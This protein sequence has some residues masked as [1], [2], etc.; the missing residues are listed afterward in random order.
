MNAITIA[1]ADDHP[2]VLELLR[3]L[4][5]WSP[6]FRVVH[7]CDRGTAL[8]DAL[9]V[10]PTDIVVSDFSMSRGD[11]PLD[12]FMLLRKLREV[13]PHARRVLFTAQSNP[14]VFAAATRLG[15]SAI[16]SKEDAAVEVVRACR[17]LCSGGT[18]Y[19]SPTIRAIVEQ[20]GA[21]PHSVPPKL[22]QKEL[23]VVRLFVSGHSLVSIAKQLGRSVSTV[24]TQKH[25]AMHKLQ[26]DANIHLVRYAY[27]NGLI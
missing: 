10:S 1:I 8:I 19:F 17:H 9:T 12:G 26:A 14:S 6:T 11:R 18:R 4:P 21:L 5:Q 3:S 7:V 16:V 25:T 23:D 20:G 15:V 2:V 22:T 13:V 24:S 27:E